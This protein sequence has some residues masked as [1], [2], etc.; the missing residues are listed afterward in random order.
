MPLLEFV[1]ASPTGVEQ[2]SIEQV[3][4][5]AGDGTLKDAST[6]SN[7]LREYLSQIPSE[8]IASYVE[9]CLSTSFS[10][11]G[12]VLQDLV[13]ELGRRLDYKVTNGRYQGTTNAVGFDGIWLSPEGHS[14]VVEVKT[15]DAY[16][17]SVSAHPRTGLSFEG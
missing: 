15:T 7:E 4:A 5:S 1:K 3:V 2:L 13:N 9:H 16:R 10:R 17:I 12:M 6:C 14:I 11:S 8:K